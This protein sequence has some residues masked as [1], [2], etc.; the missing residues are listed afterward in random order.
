MNG[1]LCLELDLSV[2][3]LRSFFLNAYDVSGEIFIAFELLILFL[4]LD[5]LSC[6]DDLSLI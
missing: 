2:D 3:T 1:V 6:L 4:R 5:C